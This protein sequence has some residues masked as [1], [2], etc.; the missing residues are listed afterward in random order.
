MT[1]FVQKKRLWVCNRR[2]KWV[3]RPLHRLDNYSLCLSLLHVLSNPANTR[4]AQWTVGPRQCRPVRSA[5]WPVV[6]SA[7]WGGAALLR[8]VFW[9]CVRACG[10]GECVFHA[11]GDRR[12]EGAPREPGRGGDRRRAVLASSKQL[13]IDFQAKH[14]CIRWDSAT[15]YLSELQHVCIEQMDNFFRAFLQ[16]FQPIKSGAWAYSAGFL[17]MMLT[18]KIKIK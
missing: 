5:Y 8:C 7:V 11:R 1:L 6:V 14:I 18:K 2:I 13:Q 9:L 3:S 12:R 16:K 15:S 17:F 10:A 4:R